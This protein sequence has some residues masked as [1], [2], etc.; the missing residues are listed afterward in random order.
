MNGRDLDGHR[1]IVTGGGAGIGAAIARLL[2]ERGAAV[3]VLDR[4]PAAAR[5][6]AD[7][8]A[9]HA[10]T[11]DVADAVATAAAVHAAATTMGGLTDVVANAGMGFNK[12]LHLYTDA[13]WRLVVGVNLDGTFHTL[14]TAIP[15]LLEGGGGSIVTV[16]SLNASRPL[17]GEA[18]Y[19]AAKAGVV[20]LTRTAALE[21]APTI[22][23]NC[24]SP[25]MIATALTSIITDD[26]DFTTVAEAGTP[27][28]RIGSVDEV[29]EVVAF[30]C[31]DA[32]RYVTGQEIVVDGGA[33]LPNLQADAIVRAVRARYSS[34]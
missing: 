3:A 10:F 34:S 9:G 22:R 33:G 32:A 30:L 4:S 11:V 5:A 19:S 14:R 23:A 17:Q 15:L 16:A 27:L 31:S 18:P 26:T 13:E 29:A 20:N 2:A 6:V 1:A 28:A 24:V 12:P 7:E 25:G 8:V 21:Y